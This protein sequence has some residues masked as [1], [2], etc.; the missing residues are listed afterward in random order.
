[1]EKSMPA[2]SFFKIELG[3][4][5]FGAGDFEAIVV[6]DGEIEFQSV[7]SE[8]PSA[9]EIEVNKLIDPVSLARRPPVLQQNCL[10]LKLGGR[11]V[12]IDT[13]MGA[14]TMLGAGAGR[15]PHNLAAAGISAD[16]VS[17]IILTHLHCD[18]AWGLIDARSAPTFPNAQVFLSR[19]EYDSWTGDDGS[20]GVD[21]ARREEVLATRNCLAP[22]RNRLS[23]VTDG[24]EPV[25]GVTAISTPGH[26]RGHMSYLIALPGRHLFNIGDLCHHHAVQ[27]A[28]PHWRFRWDDNPEEAVRSRLQAF[29][30]AAERGLEV[31][32]FHLPF[33]G[34]GR[35]ARQG[36]GFRFLATEAAS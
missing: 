31:V 19:T 3:G 15:L 22:Y 26:T 12:L 16:Q 4:H 36:D 17:A 32:G 13:G 25:E 18:H 27:F 23:F 35:L 9:P 7:A 30:M 10:V 2:P 11:I 21:A 33:P 28:N 14:S 8:F 1:M 34:L 6:S 24:A 20:T 29:S 5:R